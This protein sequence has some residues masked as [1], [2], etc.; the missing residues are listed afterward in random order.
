MLLHCTVLVLHFV[1]HVCGGGGGGMQ[2]GDIL[3]T[4]PVDWVF[5]C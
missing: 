3:R 5:L 4:D 1:V 2:L